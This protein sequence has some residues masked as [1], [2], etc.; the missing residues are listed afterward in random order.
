MLCSRSVCPCTRQARSVLTAAGQTQRRS[1]RPARVHLCLSRSAPSRC[2]C[3]CQRPSVATDQRTVHPHSR[4]H[5]HSSEVQRERHLDAPHTQ[6]SCTWMMESLERADPTHPSHLH[7]VHHATSPSPFLPSTAA[8][9]SLDCAISRHS[10]PQ[11]R[12]STTCIGCIAKQVCDSPSIHHSAQPSPPPST[13]YSPPLTS[14]PLFPLLY[15]S[16]AARTQGQAAHVRGRLQPPTL[17]RP[18]HPARRRRLCPD[19]LRR[20]LPGPQGGAAGRLQRRR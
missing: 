15:C 4:P 13:A 2:Q 11:R 1:S 8:P 19:R 17:G 20:P 18:L 5:L 9:P 10:S 6:P 3:Q 14:L 16:R 12:S 7:L